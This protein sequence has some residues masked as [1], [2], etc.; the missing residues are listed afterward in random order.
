MALAD[1]TYNQHN[2]AFK[3]RAE[4][5]KKTDFEEFRDSF[6]T[7]AQAAAAAA[8]ARVV[9]GGRGPARG[10]CDSATRSEQSV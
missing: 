1:P 5:A 3:K 6:S 2:P 8:V 9:A 4:E 7:A 10:R